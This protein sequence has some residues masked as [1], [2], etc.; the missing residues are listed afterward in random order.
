MKTR[1]IYFR[2][3]GAQMMRAF[4]V[5]ALAAALFSFAWISNTVKASDATAPG[6]C[7]DVTGEG[8]TLGTGNAGK[9][10]FDLDP[11]TFD[12]QACIEDV[13]VGNLH[14][15]RGWA[16]N[17]NLGWVST[18]CSAGANEG[19]ACGATDYTSSIDETNGDMEGFW[20]GD[21]I[22]WISLNCKDINPACPIPYKVSIDTNPVS[23]TYGQ[24]PPT[25]SERYAWSDNLGWIDM[26]GMEIAWMKKTPTVEK[27]PNTPPADWT[28]TKAL[29]GVATTI[30]DKNYA[31]ISPD[32]AI[33]NSQTSASTAVVADGQDK[34]MLYVHLAD[35]NGNA[36]APAN[37]DVTITLNKTDNVLV[38][39]ID[40]SGGL[41]TTWSYDTS[42]FTQNATIDRIR[43]S[44]VTSIAPTSNMN[45]AD[46]DADGSYDC[47][48][49]VDKPA[50]ATEIPKACFGN[51]VPGTTYAAT[52]DSV[53][54]QITDKTDPL[55]PV[56][57]NWDL[58]TYGNTSLKFIPAFDIPYLAADANSNK[59][60]FVGARNQ[61]VQ[62][63]YKMV[64]NTTFIADNAIT[65]RIFL[66]D[67][68]PKM[69]LVALQAESLAAAQ[70]ETPSTANTSVTL[71]VDPANLNTLKNMFVIP[72]LKQSGTSVQAAGSAITDP[73]IKGT[74]EY[75]LNGKNVK[76]YTNGLPRS[77]SK[78]FNPAAE[79]KGPVNVQG[80]VQVSENV[81]VRAT[82]NI[83]TDAVRTAIS[84]NVQK[85]LAGINRGS[86]STTGYTIT[87][88]LEV[89]T[90]KLR[91]LQSG[92]VAYFKGDV[93]INANSGWWTKDQTIIVECGHVF[94]NSN[95]I[96]SGAQHLGI[97]VLECK[98]ETDY[99]K[100]GGN[101]Y[102]APTVTDL[103]KV[104]IY[105]DGI[106]TRYDPTAS[107]KIS[108]STGEPNYPTGTYP[109][110]S[111]ACNTLM[112]N[113]LYINGSIASKNTIGGSDRNPVIIGGGK[114]LG[115]TSST[116]AQ[117]ERAK[118]YDLN[119]LSCFRQVPDGLGG[120]TDSGTK[121]TKLSP[122]SSSPT[123][124]NYNPPSA[125]HPGFGTEEGAS[126]SI[127]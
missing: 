101:V 63:Y 61:L 81:E 25:A 123:V 75:Q 122:A 111:D 46:N 99:T 124:I 67:D 47:V 105:A 8:I 110:F 56:A 72:L 104:N 30:D 57:Y 119:W 49:S 80:A 23:A 21:G 109:L 51:G 120:F 36:L 6:F 18:Y 44:F 87:N 53:N 96:S 29:T 59:P 50:S 117:R 88:T 82:G 83:A 114:R 24:V 15:F 69:D 48:F 34:F 121:S 95:L 77:E 66:W 126:F 41:A 116:I 115:T 31:F 92:Q 55:N 84:K 40:K 19:S 7:Y 22:G 71:T 52:I 89:D 94:I 98:R 16:W 43:E 13:K 118:V 113:Q 1:V 112:V 27:G 103:D 73:R 76:Y 32:P 125:D 42:G 60:D 86:R 127:Q 62:L 10:Q 28:I 12:K 65:A 2:T 11:P 4:G 5:V 9:I 74:V 102:I 70:Q 100:R 90:S 64:K 39:Q 78:L 91:K 3:I 79:I 97:I 20:W 45:G 106:V 58:P 35:I 68:D 85:F 33:I 93:N 17:D 54:V 38:N 107:P 37:Y 108:A 14:K 26:A